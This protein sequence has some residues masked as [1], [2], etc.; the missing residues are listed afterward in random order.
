MKVWVNSEQ[1]WDGS[2]VGVI[3]IMAKT[4]FQALGALGD[5]SWYNGTFSPLMFGTNVGF[6]G[7]AL[8]CHCD[9]DRKQQWMGVS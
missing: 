5:L 8:L 2:N 7:M 6:T 1:Y 9:G 4:S 3:D